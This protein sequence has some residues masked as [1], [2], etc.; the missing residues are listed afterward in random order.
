MDEL[1][2][3]LTAPN[4]EIRLDKAALQIAAIE[5][6]HLSEEPERAAAFLEILD[7]HA[8]ELGALT[9]G[10]EG[11][12]WVRAAGEYLFTNL[13]FTGNEAD[14]YSPS[15]SCLNDVLLTRTGIPITLA[16]VYLEVARRLG[17]PVA[18]IGLPGHFL[19]RFDDGE[20][21][22]Y[23]DCFH[24]GRLLTA[25][26]CRAL[27]LEVARV[28]IANNPAALEPV[29]ARSIAIRMLHNLRYAYLRASNAAKAVQ[30]LDLLIEAEPGHVAL[31]R[32]RGDLLT[33]LGRPAAALADWERYLRLAP[34]ADD[35]D[36]VRE[37]AS[38]L[39][40]S[41]RSLN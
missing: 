1:R 35:R 5:Y 11:Q 28:D 20:Y 32:E 12:K 39:R 33:Y 31:L 19:V 8:R 7:S 9:A 10:V 26:E 18:G 4:A 24:G 25:G 36:A 17:R 6:P 13:G 15:N 16:V 37:R 23:V 34:T 14:Y 27:A 41:L 2:H 22:T 21:S 40:R 30:A 3:W 38:L 29:S